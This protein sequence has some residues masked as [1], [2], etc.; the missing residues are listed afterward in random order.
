MLNKENLLVRSSLV[1]EWRLL[2]IGKFITGN[3]DDKYDVY[4]YSENSYG[5]LSDVFLNEREITSIDSTVYRDSGRVFTSVTFAY[6][7]AGAEYTLYLKRKDK[8]TIE[9]VD[10]GGSGTFYYNYDVAYFT[11]DD[12]GNAI[13]IYIGFSPP[14]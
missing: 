12:W 9:L 5:S 13:E 11:K 10:T 3:I 1:N 4:G 2:E 14:L 7:D 8:E 6:L